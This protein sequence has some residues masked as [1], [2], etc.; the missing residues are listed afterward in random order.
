MTGL[1]LAA[2]RRRTPAIAAP[3][4]V[5]DV[6]RL[7]RVE[8]ELGGTLPN[9]DVA[10]TRY[11]SGALPA[12]VVLGGI[13]SGRLVAAPTGAGAAGWWQEMVGPGRAI[14]VRRHTVIGLDFLGGAGGST[15]ASAPDFPRVTTQD[16]AR[17]VAAVLNHL[18]IRRAATV[19]GSSYGGMV[20][21]AFGALFGDR[22]DR[23]LVIS[24]AHESH[25]MATA[26]RSLQR[27]A[28]RLGL[29]TDRLHEG[30]AIARGLAMTTYRTAGEFAERFGGAPE[31][32][33][34]GPRFP[35][36]AYLEHHGDLFS[37]RFSPWSFLCL[38]ES[39]DL[40]RVDPTRVETPATLVSVDGDTLVPPW[41]MR[42]LAAGMRPGATLTEI[43]SDFGHD[44]FLK[45]V[46]A[47]SEII[48]TTLAQGG[49]H[50]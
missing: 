9:V 6:I 30:M 37:R 7:D 44:A 35:V 19:V 36:E 45:E 5:D 49:D 11:G 16:Q 15:G 3:P 26:L 48:R 12:V 40:H 24:A 8:L 14:D 46:G 41:Q 27:R 18:G 23:L 33:P 29:G 28:V 50:E 42:A 31:D 10:Y 43:Q 20:A 22:A 39:I 1:R 34:A 38:S 17:L 47:I 25:P 21:L 13:S 4:F 2:D 32:T